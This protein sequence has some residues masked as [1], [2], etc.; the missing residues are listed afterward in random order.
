MYIS[1]GEIMKKFISR[2]GFVC[3]VFF[4]SAVLLSCGGGGSDSSSVTG[5]LELGMTDASTDGY[6]AIY[7]TIAEVQVKKKGEEEGESG[8]QTILT[9]NTTYNLLDL[10][11]G[12]IVTLGITELEAGQYGQ[13]RLILAEQPDDSENILEV[14]H[15][16]AN[17]L[18]DAGGEAIA[19]KVP[20]GFQTGIK[21]VK[22]FTIAASQATELILD[23]D[24]A[25]SVVQA[26]KSGNWLLK[27]TI[28]VLETVDNSVAGT[29]VTVVDD[30]NEGLAGVSV[31]AQTFDPTAA[32]SKDVIIKESATVTDDDGAYTLFLPP[33]IYN[34]V[35]YT[36]GF[37][38]AC[39]EV[40]A[41]FYEEYGV[42]FTLVAAT[43]TVT[44][45]GSVNGLETDEDYAV[46]SFRQT[47][48]CGSGDVA[49]EIK[50]VNV[51][52]GGSY[53]VTLPKENYQL[54]VSA[55][56]E[57]TQVLVI[58]VEDNNDIELDIGF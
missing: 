53:S 12:V 54:V 44:V 26:G 20:S 15:P 48:N 8:W 58:A 42:D 57:T 23:F 14:A 51:S 3:I 34:I 31:S 50:S 27:P 52:E 41:T 24:A 4:L 2:A 13:L 5:T 10:V 11:N 37:M 32:D 38:P 1:E 56:G 7:V 43:E 18:I 28:K 45:S 21:I 17:Y 36:Q 19:L 49:I 39:E 40:I 33:D 9:P 6:Q 16:F 47:A 25:K 29:V 30:V 35:A 46:L 22:G 55:E